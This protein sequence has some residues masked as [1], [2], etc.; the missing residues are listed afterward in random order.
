[1]VFFSVDFP[2]NPSIDCWLPGFPIKLRLLRH[3]AEV[4]SIAP[5]GS[6]VAAVATN[7]KLGGPFAAKEGPPTEYN[8]IFDIH[9]ISITCD[10]T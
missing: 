6:D 9:I 8:L 4:R 5:Q 7:A 2:L 1:M 3:Q 10:I